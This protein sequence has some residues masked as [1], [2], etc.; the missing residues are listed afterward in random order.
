ML[1]GL[2]ALPPAATTAQPSRTELERQLTSAEPHEAAEK[3]EAL[4]A[5]LLVRELRRALPDGFFGKS[6]GADTFE[7][8]F[9]QHLGQALADSDALGLAGQIKVSLEMKLGAEEAEAEAES[10]AADA[11]ARVRDA[12]D[13]AAAIDVD[14]VAPGSTDA[15]LADVLTEEES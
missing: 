11:D 15:V 14:G 9:D 3:M 13:T 7:G 1:D 8:W 6:A 4:F 12:T 5:T 2:P 10:D